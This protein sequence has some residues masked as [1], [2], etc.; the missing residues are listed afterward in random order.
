M[1]K[2]QILFIFVLPFLIN[3]NLA[4]ADTWVAP[5]DNPPTGNR[6]QPVDVS[7]TTQT[8]TGGLNIQGSVGIG[9]IAP[10]AKLDVQGMSVFGSNSLNVA[11]GQNLIYGNIDTASAGNLLL[12]QKEGLDKLKVDNNG[13][14]YLPFEFN[15]YSNNLRFLSSSNQ[16]LTVGSRAGNSLNS[17]VS[18]NTLIGYRAGFRNTSGEKNTAVGSDAMMGEASQTN[19]PYRNAVLGYQ[20]GYKL[21]GNNNTLIGYRAGTGLTTGNNN[22]VIG[23]NVNVPSATGSNQLNIG[24]TIYGDLSSD[25]VGI[26]ISNPSQS[27]DVNGQVK[28][29]GYCIGADCI[30]QW[31]GQGESLWTDAGSY[32]NANNNN[33]VKVYDDG[34]VV[35]GGLTAA[36]SEKLT[37]T[38]STAGT[39]RLR[40]E[41]TSQNPELQLQYGA[42]ANDHWSIYV[43]QTGDDL[44]FWKG[45]NNASLSGNGSLTVSGG[46]STFDGDA[47][48]NSGDAAP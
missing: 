46:I 9:T 16:N 42:S 45:S 13:N 17:S 43:N 1:K 29:S 7:A 11:S 26:G 18:D 34:K 3:L 37:I 10:S 35:A 39:A 25:W 4:R 40:I 33:T 41:D 44:Y 22:I 8:K 14:L 27:L 32:I 31:G 12:L 2:I 19:T 15:V 38:D 36:L 20:A 47:G 30:T 48:D 24:N 21:R 23:E 6:P 5:P 28:A